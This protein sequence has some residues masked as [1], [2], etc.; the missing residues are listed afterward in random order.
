M[1][2]VWRE[3]IILAAMVR[4]NDLRAELLGTYRRLGGI[5]VVPVS[6]EKIRRIQLH[7]NASFYRFLLNICELIAR[8]LAVR[9]ES[10]GTAF[11]GFDQEELLAQIF[12]SFVYNFYRREQRDLKV[13]RQQIHW[14][15]VS[16]QPEDVKL[17]PI[18]RTDVSMLSATR[19]LIIDAKY[20]GQ[21]LVTRFDKK[22][23]RADHLYQMFAY[24]SNVRAGYNRSV[25][26]EGLLLYPK[27]DE[28]VA[29]AIKLNNLPIRVQ[30]V[31]LTKPESD[32]KRQMLSFIDSVSGGGNSHLSPKTSA[33][34]LR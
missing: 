14:Y 22:Q 20:Y 31:D 32:I 11:P 7:R 27:V 30:T 15:P 12:E 8:G 24:L 4:D 33:A 19:H 13:T 17:L 2:R 21:T 3:R 25:C 28:D 23:I 10:R 16:G 9:D 26:V 34:L 5:S 1:V 6:V 18:M 29:V